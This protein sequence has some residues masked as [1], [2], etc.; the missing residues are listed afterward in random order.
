M[1]RLLPGVVL[2]NK[3]SGEP[4]ILGR[5]GRKESRSIAPRSFFDHA[6]FAFRKRPFTEQWLS[7]YTQKCCVNERAKNEVEQA[8]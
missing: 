8:K 4:W 6:P 1:F 5:G 3:I 7:L 2:A